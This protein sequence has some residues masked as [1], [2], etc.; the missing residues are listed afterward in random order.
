MLAT[1][2]LKLKTERFTKSPSIRFDLEKVKDPKIAEVFQ[3]RVGGQLAALCVL[4][5]DKDTLSNS[6]KEGLLSTAEEIL[7]RRGKKIQPWVTNKVLD[8]CDQKLQLKQQKYWS[9]AREQKSQ[10]EYEGSKERVD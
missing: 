7:G 10:E 9:R 5:T 2:K 3:A 6:L 8:Q 4:D 1:I